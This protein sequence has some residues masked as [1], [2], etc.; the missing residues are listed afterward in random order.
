[1]AA[2]K[3]HS[4][5]EYYSEERCFITEWHN[6]ADDP[7]CSVAQAR[8]EPGVTT[9][10]HRVAGTVERYIVLRGRGVAEVEDSGSLELG[11]G[12]SLTIPAG[13]RQRIHNPGEEDLVFLCVCTP[14][15]EWQNYTADETA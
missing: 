6:L 5:E 4:G 13:A 7:D 12:D 11:P 2:I 9:R 15:F 1:M 8:V 14:R 10:W 3:Y